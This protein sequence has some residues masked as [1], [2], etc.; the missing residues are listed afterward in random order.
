MGRNMSTSTQY[1]IYWELYFE[2]MVENKVGHLT[3]KMK[4]C[5]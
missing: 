5:F 1:I 2:V 3:V 4:M